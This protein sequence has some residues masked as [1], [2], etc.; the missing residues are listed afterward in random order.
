[1]YLIVISYGVET[2]ISLFRSLSSLSSSSSSLILHTVR[3][4]SVFLFLFAAVMRKREPQIV[5]N[6]SLQ[7]ALL[8]VHSVN[9]L[10]ALVFS[11]FYLMFG[12]EY[13]QFGTYAFITLDILND[14]HLRRIEIVIPDVCVC[15]FLFQSSHKFH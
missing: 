13:I 5:C 3:F 15:Y 1:M 7:L 2:A 11:I 12:G 4:Y 9:V 8:T 6:C 10:R 14:D